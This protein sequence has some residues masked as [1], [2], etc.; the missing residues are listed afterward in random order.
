MNEYDRRHVNI[1]RS[2]LFRAAS[3]PASLANPWDALIAFDLNFMAG[4]RAAIAPLIPS[5]E[6]G[7]ALKLA[8]TAP[9]RRHASAKGTQA[10]LPFAVALQICKRWAGDGSGL[11]E[12]V[13]TK[14]LVEVLLATGTYGPYGDIRSALFILTD[15][16]RPNSLMTRRNRPAE[17]AHHAM[18]AER[19]SNIEDD[20][21]QVRV[22]ADILRICAPGPDADSTQE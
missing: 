9:P 4:R 2:R 6:R 22:R 12:D 1:V 21:P 17:A 20:H 16:I 13:D 3:P 15:I 10:P 19:G 5:L 7:L 18:R 8:Q 14:E 11:G